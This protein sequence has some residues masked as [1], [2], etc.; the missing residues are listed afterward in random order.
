MFL[1]SLILVPMI[2]SLCFSVTDSCGLIVE[3]LEGVDMYLSDVKPFLNALTTFV[4]ISDATMSLQ[5]GRN[6]L[7]T[8]IISV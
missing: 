3:S 7:R 2:M 5:L 8:T 1:S 4:K 6:V